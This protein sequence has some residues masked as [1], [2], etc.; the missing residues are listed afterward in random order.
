M[1]GELRV[2]H[3]SRK[4]LSYLKLY[5]WLVLIAIDLAIAIGW[6]VIYL[7][8]PFVGWILAIPAL[9][10]AVLPDIVAYVAIHLKYDTIWYA[11]SDRGVHLRR[12]IWVLAEHTISLA[13][14]QNIRVERG[15]VEQCFG[16]STLVI[17]TA[18]SSSEDPHSPS[19]GNRI[20]MV[21]LQ[22]VETIRQLVL[23][24]TR[25]SRSSGLGDDPQHHAVGFKEVDVALLR[26]IRDF[27]CGQADSPAE[28]PDPRKDSGRRSE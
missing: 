15:P 14:I 6:F 2:F 25:G 13:N 28:P 8:S 4:Y 1:H 19:I 18:G 17:E 16:L 5:F 3:P 22:D 12:G 27:I 7:Q 24:R 20:E 26:E 10:I 21:G 9:A 11:V 23:S